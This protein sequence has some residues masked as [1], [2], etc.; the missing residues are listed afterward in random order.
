M[1]MVGRIGLLALLILGALP[2]MAQSGERIR[3]AILQDARRVILASEGGLAL[4]WDGGPRRTMPSPAV[5]T[6]GIGKVLVNGEPLPSGFTVESR[7]DGLAVT[8]P[9]TGQSASVG[10]E[11]TLVVSGSLHVSVRGAGLWI[12]NAVALEEYVKGVVPA[13]MSAS[14]HPEALKA[15]AVLART[16][17]LYQRMMN[18][19]REYDVVAGIQDQVYRGRQGVDHR[20]EGAVEAT[21]GQIL[22][23]QRAPI[24]AAFSSTAAGP[25][26]DALVVWSKDLPYLK[27][28]DCPFDANSP[29][30]RWRVMV[31]LDDFEQKLR[32]QGYV[33]GSIATMTP[34][35]HSRAGRVAKVRILHA[36]GELVLRGEDIRRVVGYREIPST[37]FEIEFAGAGVILSGR[38]AGH[39][40]GLCQYGAKELADLGYPYPTILRYY[41]P[42]TELMDLDSATLTASP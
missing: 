5:L 38:G 31:T 16:Y 33:V 36:G 24:L 26:E 19:T 39:A 14:W 15:Q 42:G 4:T 25:T 40:V 2:G 9:M 30:Y 20:V 22:T 18:P 17:V 32:Q 21:R 8:V 41:F 10:S 29:Y 34:L 11:T 35:A 12:V 23:Y 37:Q 6:P 28:V 1:S 13:E 3:V 27:G 7:A